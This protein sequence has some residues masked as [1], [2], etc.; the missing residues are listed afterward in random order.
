MATSLR[1]LKRALVDLTWDSSCMSRFRSHAP[2]A[3][4]SAP[5]APAAASAA[6]H[7]AAPSRAPGLPPEIIEIEPVVRRE[8]AIVLEAPGVAPQQRLDRRL[9]RGAGELFHACQ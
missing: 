8:P 9:A 1:S 7:S 6:A 5:I 4:G 3:A 2:G